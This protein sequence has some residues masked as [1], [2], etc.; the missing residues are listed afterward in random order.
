M[1]VHVEKI[2]DL[3]LVEN[4]AFAHQFDIELARILDDCRERPSLDAARKLTIEI[5]LEPEVGDSGALDAIHTEFAV[6]GKLPAQKSRMYAMV[7]DGK[8]LAYND[9]SPDRHRQGTLDGLEPKNT[10]EK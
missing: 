8:G 5:R 7:P 10:E 9:M 6:Q 2:A 4:G 3:S 1:R